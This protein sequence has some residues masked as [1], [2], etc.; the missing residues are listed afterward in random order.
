MILTLKNDQLKL[1]EIGD[2]GDGYSTAAGLMA[3]YEAV[4]IRVD[5]QTAATL[6]PSFSSSS[7]SIRV[8]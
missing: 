2:K 1:Y 7:P 4:Q 3:A 8:F 5:E 6:H